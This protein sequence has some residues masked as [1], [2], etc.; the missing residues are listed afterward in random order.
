MS[1]YTGRRSESINWAVVLMVMVALF[2]ACYVTA[3]VYWGLS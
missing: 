2:V 1:Q 3:I